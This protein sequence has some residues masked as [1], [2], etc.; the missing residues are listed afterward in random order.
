MIYQ[1]SFCSER[2]FVIMAFGPTTNRHVDTITPKPDYWEG[3]LEGIPYTIYSDPNVR[4][5]YRVYTHT[6]NSYY[7]IIT[8]VLDYMNDYD[9][10][11]VK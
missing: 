4:H 11:Q 2:L 5:G 1:G 9:D 8:K 7:N 10:G 6:L 3:E